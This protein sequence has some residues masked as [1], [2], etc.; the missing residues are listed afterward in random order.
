MHDI[1]QLKHKSSYYY[2]KL[3]ELIPLHLFHVLYYT[4]TEQNYNN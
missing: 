1:Y 2:I 3:Y 4:N